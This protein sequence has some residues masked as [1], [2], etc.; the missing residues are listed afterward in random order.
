MFRFTIRELV[1]LTLVVAMGVAWWI[2]RSR[3]AISA[4]DYQ[5]LKAAYP[6]PTVWDVVYGVSAN[7]AKL[8]RLDQLKELIKQ[9]AD[10]NAPIGFNRML[11]EGE[12]PASSSRIA[13][14]WPLDVAVRQAQEGMVKLLLANGAKFHGGELAN[15][16]FAENQDVSLA[17][18]KALI[19]AGADVNSPDADYGYTALFWASARGNKNAVKLLLAQPGIKLDAADIDG[20]TALMAAVGHGHVEII[21]MLVKAGA[22]VSIANKRGETATSSAQKGLEKH[23]AIVSMLQS[24]PK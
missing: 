17:M 1:L 2:D 18:V 14:A 23:Q 10:I 6:V 7:A 11:N 21:E 4:A 9:G 24:R 20:Q 3:L 22:N 13:T 12:D 15:A 5:R 8:Q 19:E 16:A